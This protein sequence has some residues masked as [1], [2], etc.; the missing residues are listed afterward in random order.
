MRRRSYRCYCHNN[1]HIIKTKSIG[2]GG[3]RVPKEPSRTTTNLLLFLAPIDDDDDDHY[4]FQISSPATATMILAN[5]PQLLILVM[6][7]FLQW[8]G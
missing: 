8:G 6:D 2:F 7:R 4:D 5:T 3:I 1:Q